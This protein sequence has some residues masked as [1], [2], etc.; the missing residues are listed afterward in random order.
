LHF[1]EV[2]IVLSQKGGTQVDRKK[3][4]S[5]SAAIL[6]ALIMASSLAVGQTPAPKANPAKTAEASAKKET[7][8]KPAAKHEL[9]DLN[10]VTREQLMSV[11]GIGDVYAD[12]IIAGRPYK[13]K[14]DLKSKDIVPAATYSKIASHVIAKHKK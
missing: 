4:A 7:S 2:L 11:P 3:L 8:V 13:S 5:R 6:C 14:A 9:V 1:L 10:S 12:K